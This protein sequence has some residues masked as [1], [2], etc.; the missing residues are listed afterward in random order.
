MEELN[1]NGIAMIEVITVV[2]V[3]D[4]SI[5]VKED[6][7]TIKCLYLGNLKSSNIIS[8]PE[9][10]VIYFTR[11]LKEFRDGEKSSLNV[12]EQYIIH[13]FKHVDPT[14]FYM[15]N[16]PNHNFNFVCL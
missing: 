2:E 9:G 4:E 11:P 3:G 10:S 16:N 12:G 7:R 1:L 13:Y 14:G 5:I 15:I 8:T 6:L